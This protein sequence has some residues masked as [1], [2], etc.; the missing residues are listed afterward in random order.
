MSV[1]TTVRT[2]V[3]GVGVA[4]PNGMG[5]EAYWSATLAGRSGIAPTTRY[6]AAGYP[7]QLAGEVTDFEPEQH[8]PSRL[9]PQTDHGT[10]LSLY[11]ADE[12]LRDSTLDPGQ[13]DPYGM[14]VATA[15]SMGGFEFGQR[16]LQNLWSKGGRFVSAYQSFAW[17]YAVNT[18]QISIRHGLRGSSNTVVTDAAGGLD[19]V[20]NARRQIRKGTTAMLTGGVDGAL[21]PL[22]YAGQFSSG[23]LSTGSDADRAFL[24][25]ADDAPGQVPGEGGAFL[26][27]ED[28]ASAR[29]RGARSY[30]EI[31]GYAAT[32]DPGPLPSGQEGAGLV[33]AIRR[34]LRDAGTAAEDVDVVFADAAGVPDLDRAESRALAEVFG[35][36][37]VPVTAPKSMTGRLFAGGASL[38][39]ATAL[40][41]LRD[42][43]IPHTANVSRPGSGH[44][45]D[46]VTGEPR[47][48]DLRC[49]LVVARGRGGFNA[50]AV[51]RRDA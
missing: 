15:S 44:P 34:A 6:D 7:L 28:A 11:A 36:G 37:G 49:A 41:A 27:L 31:A 25:F 22:G 45:I 13:L 12:A 5:T 23:A 33:R 14:G 1:D 30:G 38:D 19:A 42:G 40:L 32:F 17:F 9:I 39:L 50:A 43:A 47:E 20:G 16:E 3:T 2:V 48:A 21:C 24:P 46:L 18:G 29:R 35:P 26:V 51:V 10:R 8:I 4:A